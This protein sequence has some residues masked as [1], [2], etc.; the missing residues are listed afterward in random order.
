MWIKADRAA[1][2]GLRVGRRTVSALGFSVLALVILSAA[3]SGTVRGGADF[4]IRPRCSSAF[5]PSSHL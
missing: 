1:L 5:R 4:Q 3:V 2:T